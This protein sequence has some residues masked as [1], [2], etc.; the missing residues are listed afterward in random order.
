MSIHWRFCTKC[1]IAQE[2]ATKEIYDEE[3]FSSIV[4][5]GCGLIDAI[6]SVEILNDEEGSVALTGWV[7]ID[8]ERVK[9][10]IESQVKAT[11]QTQ[12]RLEKL[13]ISGIESAKKLLSD[14]GYAV[15]PGFKASPVVNE[16][17][18]IVKITAQTPIVYA[19]YKL[20]EGITEMKI[21]YEKV[22][23]KNPT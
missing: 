8:E 13:K 6:L 17:N 7:E 12:E 5:K 23:D 15:I 22:E 9:Q 3:D 18:N 14:N 19:D 20:V 2:S 11:K 4:D 21:N 1:N 16:P 10:L